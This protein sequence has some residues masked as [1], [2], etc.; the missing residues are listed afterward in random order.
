MPDRQPQRSSRRLALQLGLLLYPLTSG[1]LTGAAM[2]LLL[3]LDPQAGW[4]SLLAATGAALLLAAPAAHWLAFRLVHPSEGG[5][6]Q[7][8]QVP[9]D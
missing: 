7:V 4:D 8:S 1:V 9:G 6:K 3:A 5:Q 2:P